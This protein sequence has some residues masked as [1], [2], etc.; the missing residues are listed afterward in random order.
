MYDELKRL[1]EATKDPRYRQ[2]GVNLLLSGL[3]ACQPLGAV[4]IGLTAN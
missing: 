4:P 2:H 3:K 1:Q